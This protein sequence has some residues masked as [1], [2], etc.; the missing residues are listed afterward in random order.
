MC[1]W[2]YATNCKHSLYIKVSKYLQKLMQTTLSSECT[3]THVQTHILSTEHISFNIYMWRN[4]TS[5]Y[6]I[7]LWNHFTN[8]SF[9]LHFEI[10]EYMPF[11]VTAE[12]LAN[13]CKWSW[14]IALGIDCLLGRLTGSESRDTG[15]FPKPRKRQRRRQKGNLEQV[16]SISLWPVILFIISNCF[17]LCEEQFYINPI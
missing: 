17:H 14:K 7:Y 15:E 3:Y 12:A 13:F 5:A 4:K 16:A 2:E 1:L 8:V 11:L 6:R 10:P 9:K